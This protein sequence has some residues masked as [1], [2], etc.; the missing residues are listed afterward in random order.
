MLG[1]L[2]SKN[3]ET[4]Y[5]ELGLICTHIYLLGIFVLLPI[6]TIL[7]NANYNVNN[8]LIKTKLLVK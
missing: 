6:M 7:S 4:P 5:V 8:Y 2:G 3:P 1:I